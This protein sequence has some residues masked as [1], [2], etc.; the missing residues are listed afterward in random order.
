MSIHN[1]HINYYPSSGVI[2]Y[3]NYYEGKYL[4]ARHPKSSELNERST[5]AIK[6]NNGEILLSQIAG[7]VARR[8][9]SYA[10]KGRKV[11]QSD[12][13]GFIKFGSRLDIYIPENAEI[14]VKLGTRTI[15]GVTEIADLR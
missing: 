8:I 12:E 13:L 11:K 10:V 7:Y 15:G 3:Y 14:K 2:S 1:V 5:I 9:V 6:N 4:V